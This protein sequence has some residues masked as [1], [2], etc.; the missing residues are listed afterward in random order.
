MS[1]IC[2]RLNTKYAC[3]LLMDISLTVCISVYVCMYVYVIF[4]GKISMILKSY[5]VQK[6][7][8]L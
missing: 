4:P 7:Q 6:V 1:N 3:A 5:A 8:T 2:S